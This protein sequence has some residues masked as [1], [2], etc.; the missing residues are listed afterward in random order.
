[1]TGITM[2]RAAIALV[3]AAGSASA[4]TKTIPVKTEFSTVV[5]EAIDFS[6]RSVT[7]K[8]P[9]GTF[10]AL[11]VPEAF[12]QFDSLKVGDTVSIKYYENV[13]LRVKRPGDTSADS[14]VSKIVS[15]AE[16]R[17]GTSSRQ[18]TI[19]AE[20]AAIDPAVPSIT[21]TG[22][23]GWKYTSRVNDREAL[24]TVKV[25]DQVDI[26]WTEAMVVAIET[27]KP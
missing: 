16:S 27:A 22:P 6:T 19:T 3:V 7:A 15:A 14:A 23:E 13:V 10:E 4:Q 9:D 24:A 8:K 5:V 1:M 18:R 20:I 11:Y 12:K 2:C 17:S 25:G 21:F 26:T